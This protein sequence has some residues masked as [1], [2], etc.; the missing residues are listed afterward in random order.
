M[1][2]TI[3]QEVEELIPKQLKQLHELYNEINDEESFS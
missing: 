2:L 3:S 1:I